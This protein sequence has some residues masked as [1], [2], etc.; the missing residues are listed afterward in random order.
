MCCCS[1]MLWY[2]NRYTFF[3]GF[4]LSGNPRLS[5]SFG[6]CLV[7]KVRELGGGGFVVHLLRRLYGG[8]CCLWC[9]K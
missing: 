4:G 6:F 2:V 9:V 3:L 8:C 1:E 7:G 5:Y